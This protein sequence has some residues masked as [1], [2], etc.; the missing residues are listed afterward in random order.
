MGFVVYVFGFPF[1]I[2]ATY[3][4]IST[5]NKLVHG[6]K[7]LRLHWRYI[8]CFIG[9]ILAA[10]SILGLLTAIINMAVMFLYLLIYCCREL[11]F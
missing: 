10:P 6:L 3:F 9:V 2:L 4:S 7:P 11:L 5:L 8:V 1:L